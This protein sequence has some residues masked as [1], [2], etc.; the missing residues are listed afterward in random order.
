MSTNWYKLLNT[1]EIR[2][3]GTPDYSNNEWAEDV[4]V[5]YLNFR[6]GEETFFFSVVYG[7]RYL[8]A[9]KHGLFV[10][11]SGECRLLH[12]TNGDLYLGVQQ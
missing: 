10:H 8:S 3:N 2:Q 12:Q 9:I 1:E 11:S 7:E 6:L 5:K 4:E